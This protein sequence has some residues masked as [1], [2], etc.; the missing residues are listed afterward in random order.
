M[1]RKEPINRIKAA[2]AEKGRTSKWLAEELGKSK[3]T[4]SRWCSNSVQPSLE[5][6][7]AI[8]DLLE[9]NRKDLINDK[10]L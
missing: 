3:N 5:M 7:D 1:E 6:L 4:V 9:V 8:A 10:K 2:L